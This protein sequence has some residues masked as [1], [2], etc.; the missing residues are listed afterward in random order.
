MTEHAG[1]PPEEAAPH[2]PTGGGPGPPDPPSVQPAAALD[3]LRRWRPGGPWVL[4]AIPP[5]RRAIHTRTF[6]QADAEALKAW[7]EEHA[8]HNVYFH[9]NPVLHDLDCKAQRED[10]AALAWLH[11]DI[12]P[13]AGEDLAQEQERALR[14]LRE[15]PGDVPPPTAIVFSGGGYQG[16][17]RLADPFPINGELARA[18]EAARWN[19]Q[20][21][22]VFGADHCHN[23]D[24]IMRLPGTVNWPDARKRRRGRVPTLA[25]LVEWHDGRSYDL[26]EFT[27]APLV[28]AGEGGAFAGPAED[29]E[30]S[31]N[32]RRLQGIDDLDEWGVSDRVKALCVQGHLRDV[33]GPKTRDDS[34]SAWLMDACCQ[35]VRSEVPDEVIYAVITDPD[36]GV[37]ASVL[38]KGSVVERYA[39]KQIARAKELARDPRLAEMNEQFFVVADE[40]SRCVVGFF[41]QPP[42][43][44]PGQPPRLEL[45]TQS[46]TDF[47]HR[48]LNH[49]VDAGVAPQGNPRTLALGDWWLRHPRR[50]QYERVEFVPEGDVPPGVLNLWQGFAVRPER[51]PWPRL[52]RHLLEVV[53]AG[54]RE[55]LRYILRWCAWCVQN[56][57]R[58][59]EV[60]LVLRGG[61]GIGKS[62]FACLMRDLFG[63]HGLQ[64]SSSVHLTGRF[65]SH[66]RDCVLLFADEAVRPGDRDAE[67]TLKALI[68]ESTLTI[69]RKGKDLVTQP[70]HL[71]VIMAANDKWVV[72]A[73]IDERRFAVFEVSERRKQDTAWFQRLREALDAGERAAFLDY[74]QRFPL[75]GWHPRCDV[76][77]NTALAEQKVQGLPPLE[78]RLYDFLASG[79]L[80]AD[81]AFPLDGGWVLLC[82]DRFIQYLELRDPRASV[83]RQ[84][85]LLLGE[86]LG[87]KSGR[88]QVGGCRYR[89]WFF[90]P[91]PEA[92]RRF[93]DALGAPLP[94]GPTL[95][96]AALDDAQADAQADE[97]LPF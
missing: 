62:T 29:V 79:E 47:R 60:A 20:L 84:V 90:P 55:A 6:R 61:R 3:F 70:N 68:T 80:P 38:D 32:V 58:P 83:R 95:A 10:V 22:V 5:D 46:F 92:R 39:R 81:A 45:G 59:A 9:V 74:L 11:V 25:Q 19:R 40:G 14:L 76:P 16:F 23:I 42:P 96:W 48:F 69:E 21:E 41:R 49:L 56:P 43:T 93:E 30:V 7:I 1:A 2:S 50:R 71:H 73:G 85:Q 52:A 18:E 24:R 86:R 15:P 37:S 4:T 35:L 51:G 82:T 54:D 63:Q 57:G 66:L 44:V 8:S 12:D 31:G 97:K 26:D 67:S 27:P 33:E 65:N 87:L 28:Q 89:G 88:R 91:L 34:R 64:V 72:P 78:R 13:R 36:L 94:W 75:R 17:W 53:A 77:Q